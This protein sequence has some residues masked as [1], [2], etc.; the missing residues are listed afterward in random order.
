MSIK[1]DASPWGLGALLLL[2]GRPKEYFASKLTPEDEQLFGHRVGDP[3]GQQTWECLCALVS[4]LVW[5]RFWQRS[6]VV[7]EVVSDNVSLL[8]L[9]FS[10][11]ASGEGPAKVA[12]EVAL[13]LADLSFAPKILTHPPGVAHHVQ[14]SD[15]GVT[16]PDE[17]CTAT[18]HVQ[19]VWC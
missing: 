7:L 6:C 11:K 12:R 10:F 4:L 17:T 13:E 9:L 18:H 2:G 14:F 19:V 5:T 15:F 16:E 3:A 1:I 8:T